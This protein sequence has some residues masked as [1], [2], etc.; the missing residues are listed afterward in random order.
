[1]DDLFEASAALLRA[2][3]GGA[4]DADTLRASTRRIIDLRKAF[5]VREG[6]TPA[7]DTLPARFL[8]EPIS[9][10]AARG[11]TLTRERLAAMIRSYNRERGWTEHGWPTD[12]RLASLESELGLDGLVAGVA[13]ARESRKRRT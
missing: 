5:N 3:V 6:W 11:A 8:E 12:E 7:E 4:H 9:G 10:G 2:V 1:M 13:S